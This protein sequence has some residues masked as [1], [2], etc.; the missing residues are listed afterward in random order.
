MR[1]HSPEQSGHVMKGLLI[2]A[3]RCR[4]LLDA[5]SRPSLS[6]CPV[7]AWLTPNHLG[8]DTATGVFYA[9]FFVVDHSSD[10]KRL[11]FHD[12][13]IMQSVD[14]MEFLLRC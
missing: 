9:H 3:A 4:L 10:D 5:K 2:F 13:S 12:K 1:L 7:V 8:I 6:T 11:S 14:L